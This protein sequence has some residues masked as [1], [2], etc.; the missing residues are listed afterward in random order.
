M[1]FKLAAAAVVVVIGIVAAANPA[2]AH[3]VGGYDS[4]DTR[5]PLDLRY[6]AFD[7]DQ[8]D[9]YLGSQMRSDWNFGDLRGANAIL[10]RV[11]MEGG[12]G[13][14]YSV[15]ADGTPFK[16]TMRCVHKYHGSFAGSTDGL[17]GLTA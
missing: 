3:Q 17:M 7:H 4:N 9:F 16:G 1:R 15:R 12:P 2:A 10:W 6:A 5:G 13:F 8:V 11:D 14:E